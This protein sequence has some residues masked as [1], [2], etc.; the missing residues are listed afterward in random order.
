MAF[1]VFFSLSYVNEQAVTTF[2]I[3][4]HGVTYCNELSFLTRKKKRLRTLHYEIFPLKY[5]C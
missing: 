2:P 4:M 5:M 3:K 1:L